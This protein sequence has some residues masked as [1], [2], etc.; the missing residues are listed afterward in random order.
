MN[1]TMAIPGRALI[2]VFNNPYATEGYQSWGYL[3]KNLKFFTPYQYKQIYI[4]SF[5]MTLFVFIKSQVN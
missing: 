3:S 5:E 4:L 1:N 2:H